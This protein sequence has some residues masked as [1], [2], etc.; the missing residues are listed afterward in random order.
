[1]TALLVSRKIMWPVQ[2]DAQGEEMAF[3]RYLAQAKQHA[4]QCTDSQSVSE[5]TG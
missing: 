2:G 1:M 5:H 4:Q 3:A